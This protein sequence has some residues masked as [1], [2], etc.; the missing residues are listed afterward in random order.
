MLQARGY[1]VQNIL[2][3]ESQWQFDANDR[4][5]PN[6]SVLAK[7]FYTLR[8]RGISILWNMLAGR[9]NYGHWRQVAT[10][11]RPREDYGLRLVLAAS[12]AYHE[13]LPFPND[14]IHYLIF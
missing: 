14:C 7:N 11:F 4:N 12:G 6:S 3:V 1:T 13:L 9:E 2:G 5:D 8:V 10:E